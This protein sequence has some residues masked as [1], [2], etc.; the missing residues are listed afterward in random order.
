MRRIGLV[1][2]GCLL[3]AVAA[4]GREVPG[5]IYESEAISTPDT[6]WQL[7]RR[8]SDHWMLWT[9]EDDIEHKR[10]GGAVLASPHVAKDRERPEDGAPPLHSVVADL[11]PGTYRVYVSNP[12]ARPLAYSLDGAAWRKHS[13]S[14]LCLGTHDAADGR[15][16]FWVDDRY[17]HPPHIPGSSYY[18]YVRFVPVPASATRV[19]RYSQWRGLDHWVAN[20]GRGFAVPAAETTDWAGFKIEGHGIK[21]GHTAD[22]SFSYVFDR[23]GTFH[24]AV[25]MNDDVDGPEEL[26]ATLKGE[27]I[28]CIVA[29]TDGRGLFSFTEPFEAQRGDRLTFKCGTP[30]GF[31]RIQTLYFAAKPIVPPPPSFENIEVWSPEPGSLDLCWTTSVAVSTGSVRFGVAELDQTTP[32]NPYRGRN[33]RAQL[34]DLDPS[35]TY[36]ARIVTDHD[37]LTLESDSIRFTPAPIVPPTTQAH[38]IPLTVPEPTGAARTDWPATVGVPF[39]QGMLA[40]ATDLRLFGPDGAPVPLQTDCFSRWPDGS[41]KWATVSFF[42]DTRAEDSAVYALKAA[43]DWPDAG[44]RAGLTATLKETETAWCVAS[45]TLAFDIDKNVPALFNRVGFDRNGDGRVTDD[46]RIQTEPLGAN[47]KLETGDGAFLTCGPPEPGSLALEENGAVFARLKWSGPLVTREGEPGW[48]YLVRVT[49]WKGRSAMAVNVSVCNDQKDP[50]F[51]PVTALALRVPLDGAEGVRGGFDG[52]PLTPVPDADGIWMHQDKDN[53]YQMRTTD[54][55]LDGERSTGL[56][57]AS[58]ERTRLTVVMRDFWQT[59]PSGYA[60]KP[61][62]IHVRLLPALPADAYQDEESAPWFYKLYAWCRDGKYLFRAG[63]LTQHEVYVQYDAPSDGG[64]ALDAAWCNTPLLPQAPPAYLCGTGVFGRPLFPRTAGMWDDYEAY[65][66]GGFARHITDR[67]ARRTY[68][69]MHYGDWYGERICN[70]GNNE[71]DLPWAMGVQWMRDGNRP[72]FERGLQM[73]RHF[74]T[75]DTLHGAFTDASRCLVWE[76]CFNH[77]GTALSIE[78]LRIPPDDPEGQKYLESFGGMRTGAMDP[79]GHVYEPGNWLYAALTGDPWLR[80]VAERV[81]ANQAEKLTPAFNFSIER[82]GGWPLINA[83]HAYNFSGNPYY[84][85][86]A[87]LFVERCLER[88]DP[89]SGGWLH[90]PPK[91]ETDNVPVLGGKAFAVGILSHGLLRYVE[92]EPEERPEVRDML[93][94]GADWLMNDAWNPGKGF[95]YITN[96]PNYRDAGGRGMTCLLNAEIIAYA[97]D[98]TQDPKYL[99]FWKDMMA[100][101]FDSPCSGMG[102]AFTQGVRQTVY[103]LDRARAWGISEAPTLPAAE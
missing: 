29:D 24:L 73:A 8:T 45:G 30:V 35:K 32:Q 79:Q 65:F 90:T 69:W 4:Q 99:A 84:L 57:V 59:Y 86:A 46:E 15:F 64:Q 3:L 38:T 100:D 12:G 25:A 88:Q 93:V 43:P 70:F 19:A 37:G 26:T 67:D 39:A 7:N 95:R 5:I 49:L 51:R 98:E 85:N 91:G 21:G 81:G 103:G 34:R 82:S 75:V 60:I 28:G 76:H 18:D 13:G 89:E 78:E 27:E 77:V 48:R 97:Y 58:D 55:V 9:T 31:Y 87:R 102:K 62:G 50:E 72:C 80:H 20:D 61:D 52:A 40:Q 33:H 54:G 83:S 63:Q 23:A 47:L 71:Y 17:A 10:S 101:A 6:A 41:V 92:Q 42:A 96:A 1:I 68:G 11:K 14:E 94:R 16:E 66:D 22:S 74:S 44:P 56:A 2:A 53:H 36:Q